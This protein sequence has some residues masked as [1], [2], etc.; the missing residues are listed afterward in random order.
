MRSFR[1]LRI[2]LAAL[3]AAFACA[4]FF[5]ATSSSFTDSTAS[6][7]N[8]V[9][10][11]ADWTAPS[12]ASVVLQKT[13][14]GVVNKFNAGE[15]F[16]I[17]AS[18]TDSGNPASGVGTITA[19]TTNIATVSSAALT[20]GS[21]TVNGTSYNHRTAQLT[22]KSTLTSTTYSYSLSVSDAASNGPATA[23]GSVASS[24]ATF[25]PTSFLST[26]VARRAR[27]SPP[28]GQPSPTTA[29]RT[30]RRSTPAGTAA[31]DR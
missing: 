4:Q 6:S 15:T 11:A 16:Y 8:T 31:R 29:R 7:G 12:I 30:P 20:A 3:V 13:K 17:Y 25:A 23:N 28:T 18:V 19:S 21:W 10:A 24:N 5:P 22:A 26:N 1:R 9:T 27:S 2:P 14:G